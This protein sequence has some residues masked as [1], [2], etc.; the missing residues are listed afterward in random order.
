MWVKGAS[1][2]FIVDSGIQKKL[3]SIEVVKKME[4]LMTVHPQTYTIGW[5]CEGRDLHFIRQCHLPYKINP[6]KD[7]V[8]CD[9]FPLK[10]VM[11]F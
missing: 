1:L 11:F 5:I 4:L 10:F 7:E 8:L 9:I 6:F 2:H 3:I